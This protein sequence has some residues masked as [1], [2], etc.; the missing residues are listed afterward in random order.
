MMGKNQADRSWETRA[1]PSNAKMHRW[2]DTVTLH[3]TELHVASVD[4]Q[5]FEARWRQHNIGPI[6]L[7]VLT[8]TPQTVT[9]T[10]Q[11]ARACLEAS[12][13]LVY[14]QRGSMIVRESGNQHLI[15]QGDFG[16]LRNAV[17]YEF[18]C[19]R[20]NTALSTHVSE[21]WLEKW[22][23]D[24]RRLQELPWEA[25]LQWG[26]PLASLLRLIA[27]NGIQERAL[28]PEMIADQI[29]GLLHV[30]G[31]NNDANLAPRRSTLGR[32][33]ELLDELFLEADLT[34]ARLASEACISKRHL[35]G[36]FASAGTTFGEQ[37]IERRLLYAADWLRGAKPGNDTIGEVAYAAGFS[38]P[39]HFARRFRRYFGCSPSQWKAR[40]S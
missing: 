20:E 29:G 28:S 9:R 40:H 26:K 38:D 11:M 12:F 13:E 1:W 8:T 15:R 31:Q 22:L 35:H 23:P 27:V 7:N 33:E 5:C 39:S 6:D 18:E 36:L 24:P 16:L 4:P 21:R 30:M 2:N 10:P 32:V 3:M 19:P 14:M 25:R 17:P 37:L 34:P